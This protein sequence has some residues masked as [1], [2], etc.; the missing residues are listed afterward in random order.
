MKPF[1]RAPFTSAAAHH[2]AAYFVYGPLAHENV[3]KLVHGNMSIKNFPERLSSSSFICSW[4]YN[5][6]QNQ[7]DK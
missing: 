5:N 4:K 2:S 3:S 7:D 1:T 6:K